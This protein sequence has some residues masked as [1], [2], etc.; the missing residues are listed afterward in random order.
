MSDITDTAAAAIAGRILGRME[1][2]RL[3]V[4]ESQD[5]ADRRYHDATARLARQSFYGE[6]IDVDAVHPIES[7]RTE[8]DEPGAA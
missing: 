2:T 7:P 1:A 3:A 4:R 5:A 6:P 8:T